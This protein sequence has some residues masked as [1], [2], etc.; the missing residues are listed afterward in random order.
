MKNEKYS[1]NIYVYQ[2]KYLKERN[3]NKEKLSGTE[4]RPSN[5]QHLNPTFHS[6]NFIKF[7]RVLRTFQNLLASSTNF[8]TLFAASP[9]FVRVFC[10]LRKVVGE[11]YELHKVVGEF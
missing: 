3:L 7:L 10:K 4:I 6:T 5:L 2:L 9:N 8:V 11:F 1:R